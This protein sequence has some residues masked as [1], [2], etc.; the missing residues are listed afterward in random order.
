MYQDRNFTCDIHKVN[1]HFI[2][3]FTCYNY[4]RYNFYSLFNIQIKFLFYNIR[5]ML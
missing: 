5:Y 1:I 2:S 4:I 3:I